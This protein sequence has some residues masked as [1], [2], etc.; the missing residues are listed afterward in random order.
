MLSSSRIDGAYAVIQG[1]PR[2]EVIYDDAFLAEYLDDGDTVALYVYPKTPEGIPREA[3][4]AAKA[5]GGPGTE[6]VYDEGIPVLLL[7]R[8]SSALI[9][10]ATSARQMLQ[11]VLKAMGLSDN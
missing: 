2:P 6:V 4:N 5:L 8:V 7:S 1:P 3:V 11:T 10:P 9:D